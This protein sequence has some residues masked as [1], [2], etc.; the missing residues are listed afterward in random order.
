MPSSSPS[1][2]VAFWFTNL[3]QLKAACN[4]T[5][6]DK[7]DLLTFANATVAAFLPSSTEQS[8]FL[9]SAA[10]STGY[11][12]MSSADLTT[13]KTFE[14]LLDNWNPLTT[15]IAVLLQSLAVPSLQG[16]ASADF[17][18]ATVAAAF[19]GGSAGSAW[20]DA[21]AALKSTIP[22]ICFTAAFQT[23][24]NATVDKAGTKMS[25]LI[26]QIAVLG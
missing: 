1:D 26:P 11:D 12:D 15:D 6:V 19:P 8:T 5:S 9:V 2:N 22:A 23:K 16:V 13:Y 18:I 7:L 25:D 14:G 3:R 4:N 24:I 10:A 20:T 21:L 17:L